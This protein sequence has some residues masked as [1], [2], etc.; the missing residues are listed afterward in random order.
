MNRGR[1]HVL[2]ALARKF[3]RPRETTGAVVVY[4]PGHLGDV[5]HAVP[6]LKA[7]RAAKPA[8]RLRWLVGPW[9]HELASRYLD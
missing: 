8:A 6:M 3:L 2:D 9:S 5:L 4:T 1:Y 7:L